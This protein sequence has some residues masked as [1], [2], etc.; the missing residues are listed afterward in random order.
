MSVFRLFG[1]VTWKPA[2]NHRRKQCIVSALGSCE[3]Q[4][5]SLENKESRRSK[6]TATPSVPSVEQFL[7]T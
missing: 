7:Y 6:D 5:G 4:Q 3:E 1:R 2:G